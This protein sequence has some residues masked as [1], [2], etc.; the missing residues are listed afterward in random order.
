MFVTQTH[1]VWGG[2]EWW[3]HHLSRRMLDRGWE[4][5]GGVSQGKRF[6]NASAYAA[7]HPHLRAVVMDA[8]A[9]TES[10][11]IG[12]VVRALQRVKPDVV[13]PVGIGA[14]FEAIRAVDAAFIVPVLSLHDGWLANV[15]EYQDVIDLAV[16]N[17]RLL[18]AVLM[19]DI[20][21]ANVRYIRQG[22]PLATTPRS[23]RTVRLRAGIVSRLEESTK[24]VLDLARVADEVS[25]EIELH[26]FGDGPDREQ[27]ERAL[28]GRAVFHGYLPTDQLYRQAYPNLDVLLFFSPAEGSPNAVYEA[29]QNGVVPVSSRFMGSASED[30]LRDGGNALLFDVGDVDAA[31]L[32]LRAL[33]NDGRLLDR[34]SNAAA[35]SAATF[36][37]EDMYAAWIS[38]IES[39][40]RHGVRPALKRLPPAGRLERLGIPAAAADFVRKVAGAGYPHQSGWEEWPGSQPASADVVARV[41]PR[42]AEIEKGATDAR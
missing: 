9:G 19:Q 15:I 35:S 21:G 3:V 40:P 29:M 8:S 20:S 13:I 10:A 34:L 17:S 36:T 25:D 37:D 16:P 12:A 42:L 28:H 32:H 41:T 26:V 5:Y 22:V 38:A 1:T 31:V 27:L 7:A 11:R 4:V 18:E 33:A 23:P 30:I 39:T 14:T 6:S 24:R 2:M